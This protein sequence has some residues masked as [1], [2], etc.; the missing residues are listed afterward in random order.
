PDEIYGI[1]DFPSV[2]NQAPRASLKL[3]WD[4]NNDSVRERNFSAAIAAGA[5]PEDMDLKRLYRIESWLD[6]LPP[7][8]WP[9]PLDRALA[10][11]GE[12]VYARYC[13]DC[14]S[15]GGSRMGEVIPLD[16]IGTDRHRLDSYTPTLLEAQK[17]YTSGQNWAFTHFEKTNGYA[18]QPL[19][20]IWA[21][22]P[23][24][25]NG[26]VPT[27]RD[28]LEPPDARPAV[29]YRGY[30]VFDQEQVGFVSDVPREGP[31]E[32]F[33]YDTGIPGNGNGG[34]VY[35]TSLSDADKRAIVEYMKRF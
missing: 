4:G 13:A 27:M 35:G 15:F 16:E 20:G 31:L 24:L 2:W 23:Y 3:H 29:F 18:N 10:A 11:R 1:V 30:D 5:R 17:D 21:R 9:F 14:H 25:H 32:F 34:H 6:R 7:P 12:A 33:R 19:D 22:A 26:S 8:A 28:L